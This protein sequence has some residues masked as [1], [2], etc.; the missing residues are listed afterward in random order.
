MVLQE[1][2]EA[3]L[4][5]MWNPLPPRVWMVAHSILHGDGGSRTTAVMTIEIN[6]YVN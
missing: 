1:L 2:K 3:F 5:V 6:K 4:A